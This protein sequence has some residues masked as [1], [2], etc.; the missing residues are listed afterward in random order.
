MSA[1]PCVPALTPAVKVA[2]LAQS[3]SLAAGMNGT[4]TLVQRCPCQGGLRPP[5]P[6]R[7]ATDTKLICMVMCCCGDFPKSGAVDQ[8]LMQ[9]CVNGVFQA[10]DQQLDYKSRYKSE[11][12]YVMDPLDAPGGVPT[13]AP[14]TPLMSQTTV[15]T[16][17]SQNWIMRAAEALGSSWTKGAGMVRRP[18][19]VI[20]NDPCLPPVQ[21]NIERI[22]EMKFGNDETSPLQNDAYETIAGSP[23]KFDVFRAGQ[24]ARRQPGDT[25]QCD[26][27]DDEYRKLVKIPIEQARAA[28]QAQRDKNIATAAKAGSLAALLT[29]LGALA[30]EAWPALLLAL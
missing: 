2:S 5:L 8:D 25:Q 10:A 26:C 6:V 30:S 16:R 27:K 3:G 11:I 19:L 14:P 9:S 17:P 21:S 28:E 18:D 1:S 24:G 20:V 7:T 4:S 12:S 13:G 23:D 29:A 15:P 22:A